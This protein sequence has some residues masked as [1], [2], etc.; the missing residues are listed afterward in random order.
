MLKAFTV[1][2]SAVLLAVT[3]TSTKALEVGT[4]GIVT[5]YCITEEAVRALAK[6]VQLEGTKGYNRIMAD[7]NSNCYDAPYRTIRPIPMQLVA[8]LFF[9]IKNDSTLVQYWRAISPTGLEG[10][11]WSVHKGKS[12]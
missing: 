10:Y 9:I 2:M 6:A 7:P 8:K 11:V 3:P 4:I 1:L 5:E 12:A